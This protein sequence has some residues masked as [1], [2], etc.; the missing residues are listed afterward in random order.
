[1]IIPRDYQVIAEGAIW[2]YFEN[3]TGNPV[4]VMPTGTGKS[5][6][7]GMFLYNVLNR[8]PTQRIMVLTHVKELIEQ[9]AKKMLEMWP[10]A[11]VGIYSAGLNQKQSYMPI[12]FGGNKSV[13]NALD[14]FGHIDLLLIDECHLISPRANTTYQKIIAALK[15]I[16]PWLKV[17]GFTATDYRMGQG[18]IIEQSD[19]PEQNAIFTDVAI[20]MA[21]VVSFN[22]FIEQGYLVNLIPKRTQT[23]VDVSGVSLSGGEY[24]QGQLEDATDKVTYGAIKEAIEVAHDRRSWLVFAA[25]NKNAERCS[26]FLN[27]FGISATFVHDG[28]KSKE[29][30]ARIQAFKDGYF[31]AIVNNN[32]LTT[33]FDHPAIDCIV[34]LRKTMSPG[35]WVQMLGRG[36]RPVYHP[37]YT[38][39]QLLTSQEARLAAIYYGGKPN[40][41]VLDFARNTRDLGPINDPVIP[42][43]KG[44]G[45]GDAPVKICAH[46]GSYNHASVRYCIDCGEEFEFGVG[47]QQSAGS[48]ELIAS[49]APAFEWFDVSTILYRKHTAKGSGTAMLKVTYIC[50]I[51][52]WQKKFYDEYIG[53]EHASAYMKHKAHNWWRAR[54]L[55]GMEPPDLVDDVLSATDQLRRPRKIRVW[56]NKRYPEITNYEY[57]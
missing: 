5:V 31:R 50:T 49:E 2:N 42:K 27:S 18:R 45:G 22:W 14:Q 19:D 30:D 4:V 53:F 38:I 12:T 41:L 17:I 52:A 1:M 6:V 43:Q 20:N 23:F 40:C 46:C 44:K 13:V 15:A 8:F 24:A 16:N 10:V 36:T 28:V 37:G 35:L 48:E 26:E 34:V 9:N 29:R 11:P 47:F 54:R 21:D 7:I 57:E 3:Q 32:I 55:D 51:N 39:E 56:T 33:G 25:G